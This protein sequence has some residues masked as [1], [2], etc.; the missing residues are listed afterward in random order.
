MQGRD[1]AV[2][3]AS[4]LGVVLGAREARRDAMRGAEDR[5]FAAVNGLSGRAFAP[6][7]AVMQ[8]GSLGGAVAT[9]AGVAV[10]GRPRLGRRL[11]VVGSLT[12]LGSKVVKPFARRGRPASVV[13]VA[14]VL[15]REQAGLGY[16][17]G[18]AGVVVAM[19]AA[20]TPRLP[21]AWRAPVWVGAL[22]VGVA[23]IYVGA[24]LPLDVLGGAALGLAT[25]RAARLVCGTVPA[26]GPQGS[27]S[28]SSSSR[29]A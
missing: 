20:A 29:R 16:P 22:G 21:V 26:E 5:C 24:H 3:A 12:W 23:R 28:T 1:L 13:Q 27:S 8:A 10:T 4:S 14:R 2:L 7:W 6:V 25:E 19:A 9:G 11:A 17:S 15:G 18:H